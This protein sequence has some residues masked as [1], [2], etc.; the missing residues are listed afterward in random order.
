MSE[1]DKLKKLFEEQARSKEELEKLRAQEKY[2]RLHVLKAETQPKWDDIVNEA[3]KMFHQSQAGYDT[4]VSAMSTL[5]GMALDIVNYLYE[6]HDIR[7][8]ARDL[9]FDKMGIS[10]LGQWL[11]SQRKVDPNPIIRFDVK[12]DD[13]NRMSI[14][15]LMRSD[16]QPFTHEQETA[17]Y[18]AV[19]DQIT[20]QGYSVDKAQPFVF[21]DGY[22]K[23]LTQ[24]A[25]EK[26]G[27][28]PVNHVHDLIQGPSPTTTPAPSMRTP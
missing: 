7:A 18:A 11:F 13:K 6:S 5:I 26:L 22:G 15:N 17:I 8:N 9:V 10:A 23:E 19:V 28:N 1:P 25:Y 16:K 14:K 24:E 20:S 4:W 2:N 27:L 3:R 21:T 12:F